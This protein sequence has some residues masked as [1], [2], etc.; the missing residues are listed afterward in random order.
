MTVPAPQN[1]NPNRFITTRR[2]LLATLLLLATPILTYTVLA[3]R[4]YSGKPAIT[5]NHAAEIEALH[6]HHP[7]EQRSWTILLELHQRWADMEDEIL[8]AAAAQGYFATFP[9]LPELNPDHALFPFVADRIRQTPDLLHLAHEAAGKA[10]I[11]QP[12]TF[13]IPTESPD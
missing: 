13:D 8:D 1:Q 10:V 9:R 6:A 7:D 11:G 5:T 2:T 12:V 3:V 4:F